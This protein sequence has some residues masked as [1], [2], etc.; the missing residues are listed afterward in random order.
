[1]TVG[2]FNPFAQD[3]EAEGIASGDLFSW[4]PVPEPERTIAEAISVAYHRARGPCSELLLRHW[5]SA[6]RDTTQPGPDWLREIAA[7]S[8]AAPLKP[9][10]PAAIA[11]DLAQALADAA[12]CD[13]AGEIV[14]ENYCSD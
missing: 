13:V 3:L 8:A 1:M 9:V 14:E 10:L 6:Y 4:A 12:L 5:S 7:E 11:A 2:M